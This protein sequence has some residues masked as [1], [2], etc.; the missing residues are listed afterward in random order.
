MASVSSLDQDM[1]RLRFDRYTPQAAEEARSWIEATLGEKLQPGD[2]LEALKDGVALCKYDI[3]SHCF[4]TAN[5][6]R[7][8]ANLILAP[9]GIKYKASSMPFTQRE[10][11]SHFL[12]ACE[13]APLNLHS[14]DRFLTVDLYDAKDPAQVLQCITAF[15][16]AANAVN[17]SRFTRVIGPRQGSASSPTRRTFTGD[18][19][20]AGHARGLSDA[21]HGSATGTNGRQTLSPTLTGGSNG[22]TSTK[23]PVPPVSSWSKKSDEMTS[24]PAW[25]IHQYGYMGGASQG[26][27]GVSFGARRQIISPDV[28]VPSLADKERRRKEREAEAD[29]LRHQS[30]ESERR[31][32]V[33]QE[34]EQRRERALEQDRREEVARKARDKEREEVEAE[35]RRWEEE[36]RRWREEDE[37]RKKDDE[38]ANRTNHASLTGQYLSQYQAE[39]AK[40]VS[41][42]ET[43]SD[44][45]RELERQLEEAKERE[46]QYQR[47]RGTQASRDDEVLETTDTY[48]RPETV[49]PPKM[50]AVQ[51]HSTVDER[52]QL[53]QPWSDNQSSASTAVQTVPLGRPLPKPESTNDFASPRP[54]PTPTA[55]RYN[56]P[57]PA[58]VSRTD[59]WL[60]SNPAPASTQP[61]THFPEELGMTSESER[62]AED[63][64][65]IA[66]QQK[67]KAGGWAS[68]SLLEREMER[69]RER[70]REW[71]EAQTAKIH[72]EGGNS[73]LG[74]RELRR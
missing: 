51:D 56:S 55:A 27:Q 9:P 35:R 39:Q 15:S 43:E 21:S 66:S 71:E 3:G 11:I 30:E 10:N 8:L 53:R 14:H 6:H 68:K 65:R 62:A 61:R 50:E 42:R 52:A 24:A 74:P 59:R 25:N 29:R 38:A 69:E 64:R 54:L 16:R 31:R 73:L 20:G 7:R 58:P 26:N 22:S 57:V 48:R 36:E 28:T 72:G 63:A 19:G 37:R 40:P 47:G 23:S 4:R 32:K 17:P 5:L 46:R 60:S 45:V 34:Q 12:T 49:G 1:R 33:E 13:R 44:R 2:L 70:Q 41:S 18:R 67:T